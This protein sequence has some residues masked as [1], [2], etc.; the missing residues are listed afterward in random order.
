MREAYAK[1]IHR[2][3]ATIMNVY[4]LQDNANARH[5]HRAGDALVVKK[6]IQIEC[7]VKLFISQDNHTN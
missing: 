2:Q 1:Y 7:H 4:T 6:L 5:K 3:T